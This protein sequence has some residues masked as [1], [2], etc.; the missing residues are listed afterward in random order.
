MVSPLLAVTSLAL[1]EEKGQPDLIELK[2]QKN[3]AEVSQRPQEISPGT[4]IP[5]PPAKAPAKPSPFPLLAPPSPPEERL[6]LDRAWRLYRKGDYDQAIKLFSQETKSSRR[7]ISL[8]ARLGLAYS[9]LKRGEK[10]KARILLEGLIGEKYRLKETLPQ[11]V[12]LLLEQRDFEKMDFYLRLLPKAEQAK[13]EGPYREGKIRKAFEEALP[14]DSLALKGFLEVH[15]DGLRSCLAIEVF[16]EVGKALGQSGEKEQAAAVFKDLLPCTGGDWE[17]RLGVYVELAN[18]LPPATAVEIIQEER[19]RGKGPSSYQAKI[20]SLE[21]SLWKKYLARLSPSFPEVEEIARK[22]LAIEPDDRDAQRAMAWLYF[23]QGRSAEAERLFASLRQR[24]PAERDDA[25]GLLYAYL[26]QG[27]LSEAEAL[28]EEKTWEGSEWDRLRVDVYGRRAD[29]AFQRKHLP[30]A[31]AYSQKVLQLDP[32]HLGAISILAWSRFEQGKDEEALRIAQEEQKQSERPRAFLEGMK[33]LEHSILQRR[34]ALLS[35]SSE[36]M[37]SIA[38]SMLEIYPDD[39]SAQKALAWRYL[40][41]EKNE[42]AY[43]LFSS[44]HDR[45]PSERE[46]AL[47]LIYSQMR[48]G[49]NREAQQTLERGNFQDEEW[50]RLRVVLAL[51][52]ADEAYKGKSYVEAEDYAKKALSVDPENRDARS[53]LA[54]SRIQQ[55]RY[56]EAIPILREENQRSPS[57]RLSQDLLFLYERAGKE[58]MAFQLAQNLAKERDPV[59]RKIGADF[60]YDHDRPVTAAQIYGGQETCYYNADKAS[61]AL[62]AN[63]RYHTGDEGLSQLLEISIPL[64]LDLPRPMGKNFTLALI[65]THL[66]SGSASALPY[67]GTYYRY[68]NGGAKTHALETSLSLIRPE[69]GFQAEGP[70]RYGFLLGT[71]FWNA[72]ISPLPTFSAG[73]AGKNWILRMDQRLVDESI[74]SYAGLTDPY[75]GKTWGRVLRTGLEGEITFAPWPTYWLSFGAGYDYRWGKDVWSNQSLSGNVSLGRTFGLDPGNLSIGAFAK[76]S[77]F[78]RNTDFFTYGHGGYFSPRFF[79]MT[80][81]TLRFQTHPCRTYGI[82]ARI[83]GGYLYF[84]TDGAPHYPLFDGNLVSL[85][86]PARN[87][88]TGSYRGETQSKLGL[89]GRIRVKKLLAKRLIASAYGSIQSTSDHQEWQFGVGLEYFFDSVFNVEEFA[90]F[91]RRDPPWR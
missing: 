67:A 42:E 80:G 55:G 34:L 40:H 21:L 23:H 44:L 31:E 30:L 36:E 60:Y 45:H 29:E 81:P 70:F 20:R 86:A 88:A 68:L 14:G 18:H 64:T 75:S 17:L 69:V 33:Q 74:L 12:S 91:L 39:P 87:D 53:F 46:I 83:S 41:Y 9:H 48:L 1:A 51:R 66:R 52:M 5:R 32:N 25:L 15:R 54:W 28:L 24:D 43:Q 50:R 71:T 19:M 38:R 77:H 16:F 26:R 79:F 8:E 3:G 84:R 35:P 49:K 89:D 72:P 65:P 22:I 6:R 7:A 4:E 59:L 63:L 13:W 82:D 27:K 2:Q 85:N 57:A 73:L 62:G 78:Q 10:E 56:E 61:I 11:L 37:E 76:V 58:G 90:H 47:G